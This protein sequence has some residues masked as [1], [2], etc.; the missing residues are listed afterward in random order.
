MENKRQYSVLF[1]FESQAYNIFLSQIFISCDGCFWG[2]LFFFVII[3]FC[4]VF[5]FL[6]CTGTEDI[7]H[8][9]LTNA[10]SLVTL[11]VLRALARPVSVL[12]FMSYGRSQT[13][14]KRIF[15]AL[16]G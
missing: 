1:L 9:M 16:V 15:V 13:L 3:G 4:F 6:P 5:L 12:C 11:V 10:T 2:V 14:P 8:E 7:I